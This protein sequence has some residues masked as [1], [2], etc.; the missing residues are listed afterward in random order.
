MVRRHVCQED[1]AVCVREWRL[2]FS[3]SSPL[4]WSRRQG[5]P[6]SCVGGASTQILSLELC[7][8]PSCLMSHCFACV[9]VYKTYI[10]IYWYIYINV[11]IHIYIYIY[12]YVCVCIYIYRERERVRERER[13]DNVSFP[14][15]WEDKDHQIKE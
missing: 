1:H 4:A 2:R 11:Y 15:Q 10:C 7:L 3:P 8:F 14:N 9:G 6:C 13:E 5:M 12:M